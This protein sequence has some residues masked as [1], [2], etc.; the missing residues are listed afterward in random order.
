MMRLLPNLVTQHFG[1]TEKP[2][3]SATGSINV[4]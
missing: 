3:D 1:P 2:G 4:K